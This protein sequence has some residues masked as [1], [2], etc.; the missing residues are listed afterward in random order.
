MAVIEAIGR[1]LR[2]AVIGGSMILIDIGTHAHHFARMGH[3]LPDQIDRPF[4][5]V[6]D[7]VKGL[8]FVEAAIQS[9]ALRN[10]KPV[11]V[12]LIGR[13]AKVR[14]LVAEWVWRAEARPAPGAL[15][16]LRNCVVVL[17][18]NRYHN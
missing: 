18:L 2:L 3:E 16:P 9:S 1:R 17:A 15:A 14:A 11:E 4:P 7:G 13:L 5:T 6:E 10:W 8:A 12:P